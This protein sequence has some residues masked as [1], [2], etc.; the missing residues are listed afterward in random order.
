[1]FLQQGLEPTIFPSNVSN[2][3]KQLYPDSI[4]YSFNLTETEVNHCAKSRHMAKIFS[5][6]QGETMIYCSVSLPQKAR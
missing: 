1:M 4:L 5:D 3:R 6:F 2:A